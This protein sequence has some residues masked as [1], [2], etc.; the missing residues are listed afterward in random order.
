MLNQLYWAKSSSENPSDSVFAFRLRHH[1]ES[2]T[3]DEIR[4]GMDNMYSIPAFNP[5]PSVPPFFRFD[6]A[7]IRHDGTLRGYRF[8][9]AGK[10]Q[11]ECGQFQQCNKTFFH[12]KVIFSPDNT[13]SA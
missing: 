12:T 13:V 6:S 11:Q 1:R 8:G 5:R 7:D 3:G 9:T 2:D 4:Y 10:Q